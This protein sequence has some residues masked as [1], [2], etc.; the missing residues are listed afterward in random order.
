MA[1]S[2]NPNRQAF[3]SKVR[4]TE[5]DKAEG[6]VTW[7]SDKQKLETVQT[8]LMLGNAAMTARVLKIPEDTVYRWKKSAWW[9]EIEGELRVQDELQLSARLKKIVVN[10]LDAVEERLEYG[11]Y[12]YDQKTGQMRRKPV[13]MRDAHKASMDLIAKKHLIDNRNAPLASEDRMQDKLLKMMIQFSEFAQGKLIE[14]NTIEA[15]DVQIKVV[16]DEPLHG[17][18]HPDDRAA[19][20]EGF[21]QEE[22]NGRTP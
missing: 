11:D 21:L 15:E 9:K 16:S 20:T 19:A 4:R 13:S 14:N 17:V 1:I 12:V 3:R 7:W 5:A 6:L 10:S 22:E 18:L 2:D 8:Y